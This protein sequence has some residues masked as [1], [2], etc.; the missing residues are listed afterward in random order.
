MPF[1]DIKVK[2]P[3]PVT[4][5]DAS[6]EEGKKK[7]GSW[8]TK[9][10]E[11]EP[12]YP[13]IELTF[14][15]GYTKKNESGEWI[16]VANV[17]LDAEDDLSLEW[18]HSDLQLREDS[19]FHVVPKDSTY[20]LYVNQDSRVPASVILE[21][22][23][24][25][26]T[27]RWERKPLMTVPAPEEDGFVWSGNRVHAG[28]ASLLASSGGS[29]TWDKTFSQFPIRAELK[30]QKDG[31]PVAFC[32]PGTNKSQGD[33][34]TTLKFKWLRHFGKI[35]PLVYRGQYQTRRFG[36]KIQDLTKA[37]LHYLTGGSGY[38]REW[39]EGAYFCGFD[40]TDQEKFKITLEPRYD[41]DPYTA[42]NFV[43]GGKWDVIMI[44]R[45]WAFWVMFRTHQVTANFASEQTISNIKCDCDAYLEDPWG[46][47]DDQC[48]KVDYNDSESCP[49]E[50][51]APGVIH[52]KIVEAKYYEAVFWGRFPCNFASNGF[53][54]DFIEGPPEL[55]DKADVAIATSGGGSAG[56]IQVDWCQTYEQIRQSFI[57]AG[58]SEEEASLIFC[59]GTSGDFHHTIETDTSYRV[60]MIG[61]QSQEVLNRAGAIRNDPF[62][63]PVRTNEAGA[64]TNHTSSIPNEDVGIQ[65][66]WKVIEESGFY[67]N[68]IEPLRGAALIP[69]NHL[70]ASRI[71]CI[72]FAV[73]LSPSKEGDLVGVLKHGGTAYYIWR[74]I[75]EEFDV[76]SS[77]SGAKS[78]VNLEAWSDSPSVSEGTRYSLAIYDGDRAPL[79]FAE[80]WKIIG[81]GPTLSK[82]V[83][84]EDPTCDQID[85]ATVQ[86]SAYSKTFDTPIYL[87]ISKE[88]AFDDITNWEN[89]DMD[90]ANQN[91]RG[92]CAR[93]HNGFSPCDADTRNA[94]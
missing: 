62:A 25:E 4:E 37:N 42:P 92:R 93:F 72:P 2:T 88:R 59:G 87:L 16:D 17:T 34:S 6:E 20:Y 31:R 40:T 91:L 47:I 5:P 65:R 44:P 7:Q 1:L 73:G 11:D 3:S 23:G 41:A 49:G 71:D 61:P 75:D 8:P 22:F 53:A 51:T 18:Q 64:Y 52:A 48:A 58:G 46:L 80:N 74:K 69:S 81:F 70:A 32:D 66:L 38:A 83:S 9:L 15:D 60:K 14:Y 79:T 27:K 94:Y 28:G 43:G 78:D 45:R 50:E 21:E 76:K 89:E 54:A 24:A 12:L 77:G 84:G 35:Q 68:V 13:D 57:D 30:A 19:P 86:A 39:I 82:D 85:A 55:F 56:T 10:D 36:L 67:V 63:C 26:N 29:R 33:A 90:G